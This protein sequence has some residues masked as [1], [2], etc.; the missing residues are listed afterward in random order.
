[1]NILI[2]VYFILKETQERDDTCVSKGTMY[3]IYKKVFVL[4]ENDQR[5]ELN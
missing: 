1:M 4:I 3:I 5:M 2:V